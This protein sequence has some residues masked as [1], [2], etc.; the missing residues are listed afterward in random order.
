MFALYVIVGGILLIV[1]L[2][3]VV[4]TAFE[5]DA[6]IIINRPKAVV[7]EY[8]KSLKN[9]NK[10]SV[11]GQMDPTMKLEFTGTDSSVGFIS[12]WDGKKAGKG[13]QEIRKITEGERIDIELRF[14]KPFKT[15]NNVYFVTSVVDENKTKVKWVMY[16][17]SKRPFNLIFPLMVGSLL[18]DFNKGLSNLKTILEE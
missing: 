16:G 2:S 12:A 11:W 3:F 5:H 1:L 4:T 17:N 10:W 15:T 9:Q 14:E 6:E 18:K 13:A 8:L 7:F